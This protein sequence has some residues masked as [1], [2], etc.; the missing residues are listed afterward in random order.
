MT[1]WSYRAHR[2]PRDPCPVLESREYAQHT[3]PRSRRYELIVF[4]WDGTL[5]DSAAVIVASVQAASRDL[6]LEVP[7]DQ[8]TRHIIGLGLED[9]MGYLFPHLDRSGYRNVADR[10]RHH[11]LAIG[12]EIPLFDGARELVAELFDAGFRLA[13]ATG[14]GRRGLERDLDSTGLRRFFHATRCADETLSKPHPEMLLEIIAELGAVAGGTL[15]IGDTTHD[16]EMAR[17]AGVSGVA[18]AYGAHPR[19]NLLAAAPVACVDNIA[20]LR[21]WITANA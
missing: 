18:V 2:V 4:D 3:V 20:G 17:N 13:V 19:A 16:L 11:F 14:K 9:A 7:S 10:Y 15:M 21:A 5:L 1:G 8:S 6:G 12:R